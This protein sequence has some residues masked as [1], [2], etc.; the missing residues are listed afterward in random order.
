M[1]NSKLIGI[2]LNNIRLDNKQKSKIR[3]FI[4][5][6]LNLIYLDYYDIFNYK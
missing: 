1:K 6:I 5:S 3:V 4:N 2:D